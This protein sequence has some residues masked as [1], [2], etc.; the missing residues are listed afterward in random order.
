[1]VNN[2][3]A[4]I[5]KVQTV[6]P[7]LEIEGD[8]S[9]ELLILSW[10]ST[11]GA[12]KEGIRKAAAGGYKASHIHIRHINPFPK[13][14]GKILKKFKKV[15]IPEMNKGQL[16]TVIRSTFLIDVIQYNKVKGQPFKIAEIENKIMEVLGGNNGQ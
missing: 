12:I 10:G 6:I 8:K 7:E 3:Q 13:N 5:E 2:R 1:M 16:A 14:L 11:Y 15:L 9:G 4:K